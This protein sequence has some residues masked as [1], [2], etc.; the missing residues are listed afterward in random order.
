MEPA[1]TIISKLGGVAAVAELTRVHRTRVYKWM[2]ARDTGGTG[3]RIP[4]RYQATLLL[5]ARRLCHDDITAE[6]FVL[7]RAEAVTE[8]AADA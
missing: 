8:A 1:T 7:G 5:E 2:A 6:M 4:Q 3:G